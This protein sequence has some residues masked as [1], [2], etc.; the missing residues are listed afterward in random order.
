MP[1]GEEGAVELISKNAEVIGGFEMAVR[2]TAACYTGENYIVFCTT[3]LGIKPTMLAGLLSVTERTLSNWA[4]MQITDVSQGKIDRLKALYRIIHLADGEGIRGKL[5][6]NVLN[7]P[8]PGVEN[9][10]SLL[11]YVVD[12]PNNKLLTTVV[13]KV[14]ESF[15]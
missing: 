2:K 1:K 7:E 4:E 5:I 13:F 6:L 12:E 15:K 10:R 8:I 3:A 11:H 9:D 14:L